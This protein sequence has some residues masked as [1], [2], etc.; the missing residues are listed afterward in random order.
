MNDKMCDPFLAELRDS[1]NGTFEIT[2]P[3]R[4]V[5]FEGWSKGTLLRVIAEKVEPKEEKKDGME[6]NI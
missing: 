4:T 1:G 6:Q 5:N 3:M 2:V